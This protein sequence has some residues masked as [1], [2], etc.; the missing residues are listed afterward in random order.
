MFD[1]LHFDTFISEYKFKKIKTWNVELNVYNTTIVKTTHGLSEARECA[2][3]TKK[4]TLQNLVDSQFFMTISS[5]L[6]NHDRVL[7]KRLTK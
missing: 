4:T 1:L 2:L 3:C 6:H 7:W 5:I